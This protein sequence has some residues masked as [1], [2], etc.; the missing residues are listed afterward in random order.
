MVHACGV[1]ALCLSWLRHLA[2]WCLSDWLVFCAKQRLGQALMGACAQPHPYDQLFAS[3]SHL[4]AFFGLQK[5]N[6]D[7]KCA[8]KTCSGNGRCESSTGRCKWVPYYPQRS[9]GSLVA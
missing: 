2:R 6:P 7:D 5:Q 1:H 4:T 3:P 8:G 9:E